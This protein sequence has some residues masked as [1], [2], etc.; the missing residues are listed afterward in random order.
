MKC[1]SQSQAEELGY[2]SGMLN[3]LKK[4]KGSSMISE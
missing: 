2:D 4:R 1:V 3:R